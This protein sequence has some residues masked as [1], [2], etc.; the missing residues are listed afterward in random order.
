MRRVGEAVSDVPCCT[1][2]SRSTANLLVCS[3]ARM[4]RWG[5]E[6]RAMPF[7]NHWNRPDGNILFIIEVETTF[8]IPVSC[9]DLSVSSPMVL[10]IRNPETTH[11]C[12]KTRHRQQHFCLD[13][14]RWKKKI[15]KESIFSEASAELVFPTCQCAPPSPWS[16]FMDHEDW[17]PSTDPLERAVTIHAAACL[18]QRSDSTQDS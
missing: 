15:R 6:I 8:L 3:Q 11:P 13:I 12:S 14:A 18:R 5:S 7:P 4:L 1:A 9:S 2:F 17:Y 10:V 16:V